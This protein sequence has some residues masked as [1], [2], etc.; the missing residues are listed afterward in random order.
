MYIPSTP[1]IDKLHK[2][3]SPFLVYEKGKDPYVSDS[4]PKGTKEKYAEMLRLHKI[5][6][7]KAIENL[8]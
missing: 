4:A 2:E 3:V 7:E 6:L 5:E 1:Q 8:L